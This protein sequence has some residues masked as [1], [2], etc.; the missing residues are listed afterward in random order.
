MQ[1]ACGVSLKMTVCG[2]GELGMQDM[3]QMTEHFSP[4]SL[5]SMSMFDVFVPKLNH[6]GVTL[7]RLLN[8]N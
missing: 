7:E 4:Q 2:V 8:L 3:P 6:G 1:P 5:R